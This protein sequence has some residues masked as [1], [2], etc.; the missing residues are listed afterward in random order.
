MVSTSKVEAKNSVVKPGKIVGLY[1]ALVCLTEVS[2]NLVSM[3]LY[4]RNTEQRNIGCKLPIQNGQHLNGNYL[5]M[6]QEKLHKGGIAIVKGN[7]NAL[8]TGGILFDH[9]TCHKPCWISTDDNEYLIK[10]TA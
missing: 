8:L 2:M 1:C 4:Y 5:N 10:S 7:S 3:L 9:R 6:V